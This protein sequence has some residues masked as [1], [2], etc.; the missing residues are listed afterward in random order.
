MYLCFENDARCQAAQNAKRCRRYAPALCGFVDE[1]AHLACVAA[2]NTIEA[3]HSHR[4]VLDLDQAEQPA[5]IG[6]NGVEPCAV[7]VEG[8]WR[9]RACI[10]TR[11]GPCL[12]R[13]DHIAIARLSE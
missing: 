9:G 2:S 4:P 5:R 1:H 11:V 10:L 6:K 3:Q 7:L 13:E 12:P 8:R